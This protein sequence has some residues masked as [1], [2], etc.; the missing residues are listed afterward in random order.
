[1][2]ALETPRPKPAG[3]DKNIALFSVTKAASNR[4]LFWT[5]YLFTAELLQGQ[6]LEQSV[7]GGRAATFSD[8]CGLSKCSG[9]VAV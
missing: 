1:M 3:K 6:G 7:V 8:T 5:V 4:C 2:N 9:H